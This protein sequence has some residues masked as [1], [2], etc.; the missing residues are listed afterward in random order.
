MSSPNTSQ[1]LTSTDGTRIYA[2]A[3]GDASK[4]C[5]IFIHGLALGAVAFNDIFANKVYSK[6]FYLV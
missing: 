6:E 3:V 1:L 4:Q 2:D 5:I